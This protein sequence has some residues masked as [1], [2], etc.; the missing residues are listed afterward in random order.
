MEVQKT[1]RLVIHAKKTSPNEI[2]LTDVVRQADRE[3]DELG[4]VGAAVPDGWQRPAPTRWLCLE[5][6]NGVP[7]QIA[8][9]LGLSK[10]GGQGR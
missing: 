2:L 3:T 1:Q 10:G 5:I 9:D 8:L 6:T 7:E 4:E